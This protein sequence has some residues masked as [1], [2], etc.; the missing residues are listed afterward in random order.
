MGHGDIGFHKFLRD[1][2]YLVIPYD[3]TSLFVF[4]NMTDA[5]FPAII[6]NACD[7]NRNMYTPRTCYG[8]WMITSSNKLTSQ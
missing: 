5:I 8:N 6:G 4:I 7:T 2:L 1:E 3:A